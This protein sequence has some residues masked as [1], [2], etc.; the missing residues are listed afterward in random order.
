MS[1]KTIEADRAQIEM[2]TIKMGRPR[3]LGVDATPGDPDADP[4]IPPTEEVKEIPADPNEVV[5]LVAQVN[6][7]Y[8]IFGQ[9][10]QVDVWADL[11]SEQRQVL[12]D[13][14]DRAVSKVYADYLE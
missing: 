14:V 9:T 10:E 3:T 2:L 12:Q 8:G 5:G 4:P 1:P 11:N 6:V 7:N 13:Y